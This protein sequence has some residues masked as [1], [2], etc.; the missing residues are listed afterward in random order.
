MTGERLL[1]SKYP[2]RKLLRYIPKRFSNLQEWQVDQNDTIYLFKNG[3]ISP[4]QL[5]RFAE[6]VESIVKETDEQWVITFIPP[7]W[8]REG[9]YDLRYGQLTDYLRNHTGVPVIT[10]GVM[11]KDDTTITS[12]HKDGVRTVM[13]GNIVVTSSSFN[14]K[15]VIV[16]D[17]VITTGTTFRAVGDA[18]I[19]AGAV[20]IQGLMLAMTIHPNLPVKERK[21]G[22]YSGKSSTAISTA[23]NKRPRKPR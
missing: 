11:L 9:E 16:I 4:S 17:D 3:Q 2:F 20:R 13:D 7:S 12:K 8:G 6:V 23:V 15:S 10:Y 21:K 5:Q 18:L 1:H 19:A 22:L 14:G